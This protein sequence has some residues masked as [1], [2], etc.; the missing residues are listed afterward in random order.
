VPAKRSRLWHA[1]PGHPWGAGAG[2]RSPPT[3]GT[4]GLGLFH[5]AHLQTS[6]TCDVSA[7]VVHCC[8]VH[9]RPQ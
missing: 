8:G 2:V 4:S 1:G 6:L 3:P 9:T 7:T 5:S